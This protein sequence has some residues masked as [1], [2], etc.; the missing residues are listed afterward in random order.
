MAKSPT[1]SSAKSSAKTATAA[2]TQ[3]AGKITDKAAAP[4]EA[5]DDNA[6]ALCAALSS[7]YERGLAHEIQEHTV[8]IFEACNF[9][10]LAGQRIGKVIA[11]LNAVEEQLTAMLARSNGAHVLPV[12]APARGNGLLNGPSLDGDA[13]HATQQDIDAMFA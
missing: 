2:P 7:G 10:D 1:R 9:Q 11:T 13:G 4:A 3:K 5:I 6:R 8:R 12:A